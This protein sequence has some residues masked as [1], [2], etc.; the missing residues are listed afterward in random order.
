MCAAGLQSASYWTP[1]EKLILHLSPVTKRKAVK[2][3]GLSRGSSN[4]NHTFHEQ[5][6]RRGRRTHSEP[7]PGNGS[8][9][10]SLESIPNV[11][12]TQQQS[13]TYSHARNDNDNSHVVP[14]GHNKMANNN[15]LHNQKD[16]NNSHKLGGHGFVNGF[17]S[18]S[19]LPCSSPRNHR[20]LLLRRRCGENNV[21][22]VSINSSSSLSKK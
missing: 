10:A 3:Q 6:Q 12:T 20:N 5:L 13:N 11:S 18:G 21:A 7:S 9:R 15:S 2:S 14:S 16:G 17:Q 4:N 19:F 22:K 8:N 1:V